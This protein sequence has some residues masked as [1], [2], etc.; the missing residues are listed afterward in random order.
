LRFRRDDQIDG[1]VWTIPG[2]V[3][4]GPKDRTPDFRV[5]LVPVALDVIDQARRN[6]RDGFLSP[7]IRKGAIPDVTM[8]RFM[9]RQGPEAR[10]HGFRS[11]LRDW[12]AEDTDAAHEVA[13]TILGPTVGG[14]V[15]RTCRRTD[16][17]EQRRVHLET[18]AAFLTSTGSRQAIVEEP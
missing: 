18:W 2:E 9:K 16:D 12:L 5:P 10:P 1:D 6:A 14:T 8:S 4:K 7:S 3:M 17:P 11:S 13:E 15:A